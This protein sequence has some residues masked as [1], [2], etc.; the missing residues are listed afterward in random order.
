[1]VSI[2]KSIIRNVYRSL[3][4]ATPIMAAL[5]A[6]GQ[7]NVEGFWQAVVEGTYSL[8]EPSRGGIGLQDALG[9]PRK[10]NPS[11]IVEP[12]D[13]QV[14]YQPWAREKQKY[15][16]ANINEPTKPEFIDP[17]ARCL[18]DG[19][20][21]SIFWSAFQILQFPGYVVVEYESN[22]PYRIIPL[23]GRPHL[24]ESIKLWM[25]DSRGHWEGN[26]LVVDVTNNN[27]KSRLSNV[28]DFASDKLHI[29]ERYT[30]LDANHMKYEAT[31]DDPS[32]YTRPW[33]IAADMVRKHVKDPGYEQWEEACHEGERNVADSLVTLGE[34]AEK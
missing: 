32:V 1:M 3:T 16:E 29:V 26:A 34:P 31:L 27:S 24:G 14:P 13:G 5:P 7:P 21:R 9:I 12:T 15:I 30:F 17:Q 6:C 33:K 23:D 28:G 18:P 8:T 25:G 20:I 19:P 22:H 10:H 2:W 4:V 11:R